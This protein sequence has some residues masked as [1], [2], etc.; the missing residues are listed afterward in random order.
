[1]G[2]RGYPQVCGNT[3][4]KLIWRQKLY[5]TWVFAGCFVS[6]LGLAQAAITVANARDYYVSAQGDDSGNATETAPWKTIDKVNA[7]T[8]QPGDRILL[9]G[10]DT[11]KGSIEL[12]PSDRGAE[13]EKVVISSYG[14]GRAIIDAGN[15]HGLVADGCDHLA[16]SNLVFCGSGRNNGSDGTGVLLKNGYDLEVDHLEVSGFRLDGIGVDG[17]RKARITRVHAHDNGHAGIASGASRT[18]TDLYVGHCVAE[19]NAGDPQNLTNHSGNGIVIGRARNVLVEYCVAR[20]NGWDMPREGNGPVGIWCH[21]AE[22]IVIQHCISHDNR[23]PSWDGGGFDLDGGTRNAIL[24]YNLSYNNDGPGYF[25]CQF[26]SAPPMENNI[27]RYN[28][29]QNDGRKNNYKSAFRISSQDTNASGCHIYN[30]TI[31]TE[32]GTAIGFGGKR[33]PDVVFRNNIIV[34]ANEHIAGDYS[35]ARFEGNLWWSIG[36]GGF[37]VGEFQSFD[38]WV[39]ATGQEKLGG[40][41]VGRYADPRLVSV[42]EARSDKPPQLTRLNSYRLQADS[43]CLA[44][45]VVIHDNGGRDF[46]GTEVPAGTPPTIGACQEV[47]EKLDEARRVLGDISNKSG[48]PRQ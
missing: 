2:D 43:P 3:S 25:V 27:I 23:S 37:R 6:A 28:I 48:S 38:D 17:V 26:Y 42:G 46:W 16:I 30:N 29:S 13:E 32:V 8:L 45:G 18:S 11:F 21:N 47:G 33:I 19:N 9:R 10:G 36:E 40:K 7:A 24:Q 34:S 39:A 12:D 22:D 35:A 4:D 44:S 15:G 31:Y 14:E 1:M 41:V 20:H 5:R